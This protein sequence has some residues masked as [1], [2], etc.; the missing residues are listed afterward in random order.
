MTRYLRVGALAGAAAIL[1]SAI[2]MGAVVAQDEVEFDVYDLHTVNPG[3]AFTQMAADAFMG[4]HPGVKINV[5]TLENEALKDRISA[6]MAAGSP[7][8][9]FQSWGSGVLRQ[10]V[11][12]GMVQDIT[13]AV[14]DIKDEISPG[15]MSLY[16]LDGRQYGI[17]YNF[18]LVGM[19]YNSDLLAEAGIEAPATTWQEF[20]DQVQTAQGRGH[21]AHLH[22]RAATS[23]RP[24]SGGPISPPASVARRPWTTP[25]PPAT[26]PVR[27]SCA[28]ARSS[29]ASWTWTPSSRV[30]WRP[31]IDEQQGVFGNGEAA[32]M[33]QGQWA[34][35]SQ[36]AQSASGQGI[37]NALGWAQFPT[38]EGGAGLLTD[39]FGGGDGYSIGRDAP[40]EAVEFVK[41]LV[42]PDVASVWQSFNDGTLL[43]TNGAEQYITDPILAEVVQKRN[44]ATFAQLYLDQATSPELGGAINAAVADLIAGVKSPEEVAQTITEE[45]ALAA[46]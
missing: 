9:V 40:P 29:S 22:R 27:P 8:D 10:Q 20:L 2:G 6:D 28:R 44:E 45:A 13:D 36:R 30:R 12:A 15:A 33:L 43:P 25:S 23:G 37:G 1:A 11:D 41:Y 16:Q 3:L 42:S 18:G 21:H 24:C 31:R 34:I 5:V 7:P 19:W 17:P 4:L 14:A 35:G 39:V 38:V 32:Y 26:G 46:G